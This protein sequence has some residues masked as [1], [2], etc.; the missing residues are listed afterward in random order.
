MG[1]CPPPLPPSL[2]P[3]LMAAA[4]IDMRSYIQIVLVQ[5]GFCG[6]CLCAMTRLDEGYPVYETL[7]HMT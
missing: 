1:A 2:A 5:K 7:K 6:R 3:P 4:S